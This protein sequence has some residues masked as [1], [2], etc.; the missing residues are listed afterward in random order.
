MYHFLEWNNSKVR[1]LPSTHPLKNRGIMMLETGKISVVSSRVAEIRSTERTKISAASLHEL[2][3]HTLK[4]FIRKEASRK[5]SLL[6]ADECLGLSTSPIHTSRPFPK[7]IGSLRGKALVL[8]RTQLYC[9]LGRHEWVYVQVKTSE[10][11]LKL[12]FSVCATMWG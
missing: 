8:S 7:W 3:E 9:G 2:M 11:D 1:P 12:C 4:E 5:R 10:T 6:G